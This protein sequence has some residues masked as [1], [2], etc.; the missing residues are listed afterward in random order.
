MS[1]NTGKLISR[2]QFTL[3]PIT[4]EVKRRVEE[5]SLAQ[6]QPVIT[7]E[8]PL[9]EWDPNQEVENI[10]LEKEDE[11]ENEDTDILIINDGGNKEDTGRNDEIGVE[12]ELDQANN[13]INEEENIIEDV[14]NNNEA[15]EGAVITD[16][17]EDLSA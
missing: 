14:I 10:D 12:V 9:F 17:L 6:Y 3:L 13:E 16:N 15:D 7:G 5:F 8:C 1:L 4:K 2:N 11:L